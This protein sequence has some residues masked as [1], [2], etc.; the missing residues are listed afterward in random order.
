MTLLTLV[1]SWYYGIHDIPTFR[2]LKPYDVSQIKS[3]KIKLSM[4]RKLISTIEHRA[5]IVNKQEFL[6]PRNEREALVL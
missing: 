5:I 3:G 1:T 6:N 4:M 2:K